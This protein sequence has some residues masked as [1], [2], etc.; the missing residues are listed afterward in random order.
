[1][2]NIWF[3]RT[4]GPLCLPPLQFWPPNKKMKFW[5]LFAIFR[6]ICS[7]DPLSLQKC[8]NYDPFFGT[9]DNFSA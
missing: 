5:L 7:F 6:K 8:C 3:K 4:F 9:R 1:M 2:K